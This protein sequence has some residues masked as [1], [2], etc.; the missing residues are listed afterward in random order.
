LTGK[1]IKEL[2]VSRSF[3]TASVRLF[4]TRTDP[5]ANLTEFAG[6][7]MLVTE[8]DPDALGRLDLAFFCGTPDEGARYLDWPRQRG[9]VGIDLTTASNGAEGV[10]L[11]NMTVNPEE[12]SP[13]PG[14]IATPH[15]IAQLVSNLLAPVVQGC[16]PVEAAAVVFQPASECGEG[17]I[18]ELYQQTLGLLNFQDQPQRIFGRQLAFNL[19]PASIYGSGTE[20]G[21]ARRRH[22]EQEVRKVARGDYRLSLQVV[23]A[24][25]FHGHAALLHLVLPPGVSKDALLG[26]YSDS[27]EVTLGRPGEP[28]TPVERAGQPGVRIGVIDPGGSPSTYWIWAVSDNLVSGTALNAVR[29]AETLLE[30]G[31]AGDAS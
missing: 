23:L 21:G 10:P 12:V 20:P 5:E 9:F 8:P 27:D 22:L 2:L 1:G 16:G 14:I 4:A 28:A 18:E 6:E 19:I 24:P 26:C 30:R 3:P 17:G 31:L 15:P 13:A 25:V 7:A 29:I 11:V